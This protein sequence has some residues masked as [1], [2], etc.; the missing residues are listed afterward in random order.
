MAATVLILACIG[1][2]TMLNDQPMEE[3]PVISTIEKH[4]L[5]GQKSTITLS[6]GSLV[7]LNSGSQ[8]SYQSDFNDSLRVVHLKG[9][10]FFEVFKDA[11]KPFIVKCN[12]LEI[13][14]LGTSFDVN[15][16]K[17]NLLQVSL[18]TGKVQ[19]NLEN[20]SQSKSISVASWRVLQN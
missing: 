12:D 18:L 6:D 16:M 1:M 15:A 8:I 2:L 20:K 7:W 5:P 11:D 13:I 17:D 10:A 14:A 3:I 19:V 4:T 9:Q